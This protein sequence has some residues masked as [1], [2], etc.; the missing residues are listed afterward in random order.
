VVTSRVGQ[1]YYRQ[2]I[3]KIWDGK[4][5]LT[6][7]SIKDILISSHIKGWSEC[8]DSERLDP[9]NGILLSPNVDSLFDRHLISFNDDGSMVLS[10]RITVKELQVLGLNSIGKIKVSEGMKPYLKFHRNKLL[11]K[12]LS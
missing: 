9:D 2:E 6:G 5:S 3:L 8:N 7:C 4:C 12:N 11:Q 10:N 1:G